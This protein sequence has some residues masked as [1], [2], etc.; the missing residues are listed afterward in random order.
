MHL[1]TNTTI[2]LPTDLWLPVT[3]NVK[4]QNS[5]QYAAGVFYSIGHDYDISVEGYYKTMTNLIAY[6]E[7]ASFFSG[8]GDDVGS[9]RAW[10]NEIEIGGVGESYG[11]ELLIKKNHGKTTGWIGY[12]LSWAYRQFDNINFGERYPYSY[13]RRHDIGIVVVHKFNDKID[14]GATWVYGTGNSYTLALERYAGLQNISPWGSYTPLIDN[15][16]NRNNYRMPAYHRLDFSVNFNKQKKYGKRIW[17]VGAYNLYNRKNPFYM[18]FGYD[19]HHNRV[20]KQYSLF[21]IIPSIS[22]K[23]E[24]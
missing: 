13:D 20:L 11:V 23:Y 12:T 8:M 15:I 2:G 21:P 9:D 7:G 3:E 5:T 22:Y 14:I 18:D 16:E 24:F 1:L 19:S 4:P 10:E 6:K 17:S